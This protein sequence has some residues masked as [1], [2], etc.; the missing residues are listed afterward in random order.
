MQK[1]TIAA[2]ATSSCL[3]SFLEDSSYQT[4]VWVYQGER[5]CHA[6]RTETTSSDEQSRCCFACGFVTCKLCWLTDI[7]LMYMLSSD[8]RTD[9]KSHTQTRTNTRTHSRSV[10]VMKCMCDTILTSCLQIDSFLFLQKDIVH[11][12]LHEV[13]KVFPWQSSF[14]TAFC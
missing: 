14:A 10:K 12:F 5:L 11:H 8:E 3:P 13:V 1:P 9:Y 7:S 6:A 4:K 2:K